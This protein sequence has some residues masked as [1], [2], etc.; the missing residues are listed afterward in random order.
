MI[1]LACLAFP[2]P[3]TGFEEALGKLT[4]LI[5]PFATIKREDDPRCRRDFG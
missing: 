2:A 5:K 1:C 4:K 3:L